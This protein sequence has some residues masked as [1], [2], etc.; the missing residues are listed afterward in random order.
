MLGYF[1]GKNNKQKY[2]YNNYNKIQV[3]TQYFLH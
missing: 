3:I 2:K 1:H